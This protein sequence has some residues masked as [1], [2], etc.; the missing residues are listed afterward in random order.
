MRSILITAAVFAVLV[1]AFSVFLL[2]QKST[3]PVVKRALR[4]TATSLPAPRDGPG[5]STFGGGEGGWVQTFDKKTGELVNEFRADTFEPPVN[6]RVHVVRPDARFYA[7]DGQVLT[8]KAAYGDITMA[9]TSRRGDRL[10]AMPGQPPSNGTLYDVTIGLLETPE[11]ETPILT[12]TLPIVAFD[13]DTL[14]LNT[15]PMTVDGREVMA[16]RVPITVRGRDYDFDGQGL[17]IRY[18]QRDRRLEF[19]EVAHGRRLVIKNLKAFGDKTA[20]ADR[21]ADS[22]PLM[23]DGRPIELVAADEAVAPRL[24]AEERQRRRDRR[25]ASTRRA[26]REAAT[27]AATAPSRPRE[28][29]AYRATFSDDVRLREAGVQVGSADRMTATFTFEPDAA[30]TQPSS[31]STAPPVVAPSGSVPPTTRPA[32]LSVTRPTDGHADAAV[33]QPATGPTTRVTTRPSRRAATRPATSPASSPAAAGPIEITWTGKLVVTPQKL[34]ESGLRGTADRIVEF[35]GRPVNLQ[36]DGS[37][38]TAAYVWAS[39]EGNRFRA[40]PDATTPRVTLRDPNGTT[41]TTESIEADGDDAI[42]HG[43]SEAELVLAN[44]GSTTTRPSTLRTTWTDFAT[45]RLATSPDGTRG[46]ERANFRGNVDVQHPQLKLTSRTLDL[47]F[48]SDPEKD[49]PQLSTVRADGVVKAAVTG[50]DGQ[51]QTIAAETL[52]LATAANA[53]GTLAVRSMHAQGGVVASDAKQ[54]LSA[55]DLRTTLSATNVEKK[56]DGKGDAPTAFDVDQLTAAGRV[57]FRTADG[58]TA[59]ADKLSVDRLGGAQWVTLTGTPARVADPQSAISGDRIRVDATGARANI[60]GP[61]T[62]TGRQKTAD[63][64]PGQ[65]IDVVWKQSLTYDGP[66]NQAAV[67]GAVVVTTK[68]TDGTTNEAKGRSLEIA[69]ADAPS[70]KPTATP[71]TKPTATPTG[72]GSVGGPAKQVKSLTLRG[73]AGE[74][75]EISSHLYAAGNADQWVRRTFLY[76]PALTVQ[77]NAD[78]SPGAIDVPSGGRMLYEEAAAATQPRPAATPTAPAKAP[79]TGMG[80]GNIA[81]QWTRSMT[82]DP[83][84]QQAILEGDVYVVHRAPGEDDVFL[85]APR[86]VADIS[87]PNGPQGAQLKKMTADQGATMRAKTMRIEAPR[88]IF[89]PAADRVIATGTARQPVEWFDDKGLS[90]GSFA[91]M[92]WNVKTNQPEKVI[93]VKVEVNR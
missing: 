7:K 29:V 18:N 70:T 1:A 9:E 35:F 64:K 56:A 17:T 86:L 2:T 23:L 69:F 80:R 44:E 41:L 66:A 20:A 42:L 45:L 60:D 51:T 28:I 67:V 13:N 84:K 43:R 38:I 31:Q 75:V 50:D 3:V 79:A 12:A 68:G 72:F 15:V 25:A 62:L 58:A 26:A 54:T 49:R 34:A 91:E 14:R 19:L 87:D 73:G 6:N 32:Q 36:R 65:P 16:D 27:R 92:W 71:A 11:S 40:A 22:G 5:G 30:A 48:V 90:R 77:T 61:G 24:S 78:G 88:A 83:T 76:A 4:G 81:L 74:N 93:D 59:S 39:V 52:E 53:D 46:I 8:L 57:T 47:G 37:L 89:E 21:V 82:Y 55:D 33:V 63:G 10:G 85:E